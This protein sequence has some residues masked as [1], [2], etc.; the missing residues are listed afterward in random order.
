VVVGR[1]ENYSVRIRCDDEFARARLGALQVTHIEF[2][3]L[4]AHAPRY[5]RSRDKDN[6]RLAR[7]S[8]LV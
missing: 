3:R 1:G 2:C 5:G 7:S 8:L 6:S 4:L